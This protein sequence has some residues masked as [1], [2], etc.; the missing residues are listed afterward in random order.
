MA[1]VENAALRRKLGDGKGVRPPL[2]D[3]DYSCEMFARIFEERLRSTL[4]KSATVEILEHG[5]RRYGDIVRELNSEDLIAS[6]T[7]RDKDFAGFMPMS[8]GFIF[9][10]VEIISGVEADFSPNVERPLT[11]VDEALSE[12]FADDVYVCFEA[13]VAPPRKEFSKGALNFDRFLRNMSSVIDIDDEMEV[14]TVEFTVSIGP[15]MDPQ[16]LRLNVFL[17][18]LDYYKAA[19][20]AV[21]TA[22]S[23]TAAA[24]ARAEGGP[25][26]LW[27][28][29]MLRALNQAE[30]PVAAVLAQFRVNIEE[31]SEFTP[32]YVVELPFLES[33]HADLRFTHS[34]P[35]KDATPICSGDIGAH[36][37][38]RALK[39]TDEPVEEFLA[40]LDGFHI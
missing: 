39:M 23:S 3:A 6:A 10:L 11:S 32:G 8:P 30:F 31:L 15:N 21:R 20:L 28:R 13:A 14:F 17:S 37:D 40:M 5:V 26:A 34:G 35:L 33:F 27:S 18:A 7:L 12:D 19:E 25:N 2:R 16:P 38:N 29:A 22:L 4:R 1:A 24:E 9:T 36:G